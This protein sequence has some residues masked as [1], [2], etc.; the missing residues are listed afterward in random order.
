MQSTTV[1]VA[2]ELVDEYS[3][4]PE[5][6]RRL[7]DATWQESLIRYATPDSSQ[8]APHFSGALLTNS[9]QKV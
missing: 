4:T 1:Q 5:L 2:D 3:I 9:K 6:V 8:Y 7:K